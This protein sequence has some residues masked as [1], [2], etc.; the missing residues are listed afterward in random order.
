MNRHDETLNRL[1]R[2]ARQV[3]A[4][5][6]P[7]MPLGFD[8][9]V[10]AARRAPE[11]A[12]ALWEQIAIRSLPAVAAVSVACVLASHHLKPPPSLDELAIANVIVK[13]SL[14]P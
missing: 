14:M 7:P 2:L 8:T 12:S 4:P 11:P 13:E 3:P 10:V 5:K 9:R 6:P 1:A